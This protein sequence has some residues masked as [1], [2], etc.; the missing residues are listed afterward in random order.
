MRIEEYLQNLT[1]QGV[2]E[3]VAS[4]NN[5][6]SYSVEQRIEVIPV[7]ESSEEASIPKEPLTG[8]IFY[9]VRDANGL[10]S[11]KRWPEPDGNWIRSRSERPSLTLTECPHL[12]WTPGSR[13]YRAETEEESPY[14]DTYDG[15]RTN[16]VRLIK[17]L[18]WTEL[19]V[20]NSGLHEITSGV[21]LLSGTA[22]ANISGGL[23]IARE[24]VTFEGTNKAIVFCRDYAVGTADDQSIVS[25][26]ENIMV[27][28]FGKSHG[29]Y[30]GKEP[31]VIAWGQSTVFG[32]GATLRLRDQASARLVDSQCEA[33]HESRAHAISGYNIVDLYDKATVVQG[34]FLR[35]S[36]FNSHGSSTQ[37]EVIRRI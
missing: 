35:D 3:L 17:E 4:G 31:D 30:K 19:N 33:K 20:F 13:V 25:G 24:N 8:R 34:P 15:I 22:E 21:W 36:Q 26:R 1:N 6:P 10:C 12:F 29:Y 2:E 37:Q 27:R 5:D 14:E 18:D 9:K 16:V 28:H 7:S 32:I 11:G 23:L